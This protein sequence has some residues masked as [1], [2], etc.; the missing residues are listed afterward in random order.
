MSETHRHIILYAKHHYRDINYSCDAKQYNQQ[1]EDLCY[2]CSVIYEYEY[3]RHM[4]WTHLVDCFL[5]YVSPHEQMD[6]LNKIF[7]NDALFSEFTDSADYGKAVASILSKLAITKVQGN[8][9]MEGL[10]EPDYAM[11]PKLAKK[12]QVDEELKS[13]TLNV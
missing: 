4:I 5:Q 12:Q 2:I 7:R 10:R 1:I 13:I 8:P 6:Y 3:T 9:K 11:F